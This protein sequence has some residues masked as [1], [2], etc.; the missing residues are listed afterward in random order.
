LLLLI[1]E[2][3][4]WRRPPHWTSWTPKYFDELLSKSTLGF[5]GYLPWMLYP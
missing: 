5:T 1:T 2:N 4:L 3:S